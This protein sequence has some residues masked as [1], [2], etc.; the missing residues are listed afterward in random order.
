M[1][2][3]PARMHAIVRHMFKTQRVLA[4]KL[5]VHEAVVSYWLRGRRSPTV[6]QL[7][8]LSD[9]GVNVDYLLG[10]SS[11]PYANN[12]AGSAMRLSV[13]IPPEDFERE[14]AF[15][16]KLSTSPDLLSA[17][18]ALSEGR[19]VKTDLSEVLARIQADINANAPAAVEHL[20]RLLTEAERNKQLTLPSLDAPPPRRRKPSLSAEVG[21]ITVDDNSGADVVIPML[22]SSIPAGDRVPIYEDLATSFNV[23]QY[24]RN[25]FTMRVKG[26]SMVDAGINDGDRVI[27]KRGHR[28]RDGDVIAAVID[29]ELTLKGV[30][31]RDGKIF[32]VPANRKYA[33]IEVAE[34]SD[35]QCIGVCI[36]T[37]RPPTRVSWRS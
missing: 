28:F 35:F 6:E 10:N 11:D 17:I 36:D 5:D 30:W 19:G 21:S 33:V 1:D 20:R 9:L 37:F 13:G 18:N 32:L 29:G 14:V 25:C 15:R 26:D 24:Y 23:T 3:I 8:A 7:E 31:K 2:I 16:N 22:E 34:E 4:N 12:E 27:I